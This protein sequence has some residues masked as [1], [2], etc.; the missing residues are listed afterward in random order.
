MTQA[1]SSIEN[2]KV[3]PP[4]SPFPLVLMAAAFAGSRATSV[5]H[6]NDLLGADAENDDALVYEVDDAW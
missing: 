2:Q 4:T 1:L 3:V 6:M 5:P